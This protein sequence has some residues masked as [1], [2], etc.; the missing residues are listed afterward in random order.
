M[1]ASRTLIS[2]WARSARS[3]S[4]STAGVRP[5]APSSTTGFRG[6][7]WAAS[8]LRSALSSIRVGMVLCIEELQSSILERVT[9]PV[10]P[11]RRIMFLTGP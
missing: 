9:D 8:A 11:Y 10:A 1:P 5:A 6:C 3:I 4:C 7:A 2:S